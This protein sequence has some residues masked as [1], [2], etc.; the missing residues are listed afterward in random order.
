MSDLV[1]VMN[2]IPFTNQ[3]TNVWLRK[4]LIKKYGVNDVVMDKKVIKN[5]WKHIHLWIKSTNIMNWTDLIS[6]EEITITK[7]NE[8]NIFPI[9][10]FYEIRNNILHYSYDLYDIYKNSKWEYIQKISK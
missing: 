1:K 10:I 6:E 4:F 8:T 2:R 3:I 5:V 9:T 7:E